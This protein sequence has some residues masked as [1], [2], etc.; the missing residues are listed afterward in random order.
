[1]EQK[2][3]KL[4]QILLILTLFVLAG[5]RGGREI[6]GL[7]AFHIL[8]LT[9]VFILLKSNLCLHKTSLDLSIAG[10]IIILTIATIVSLITRMRGGVFFLTILIYISL[11]YIIVRI[12]DPLFLKKFLYSIVFVCSILSII[13]C[14][15]NSCAN[16]PNE[17]L[18]A[19]FLAT[20]TIVSLCLIFSSQTGKNQKILLW[21]GLLI[22]LTAQILLFSRGAWV[23]LII[24]LAV[25]FAF[26]W[27]KLLMPVLILI[28]FCSTISLF[29]IKPHLLD[30]TGFKFFTPYGT[31][32]TLIWRVAL[33]GFLH[34]PLLGW[35]IKSFEN[36]YYKFALPFE[37][38]VGRY[39]RSTR[40]A[41][42][43]Y[44]HIAVETGIIG[45][46]IFLLLIFLV[47]K[48][49]IIWL[50]SD[51]GIDYWQKIAC[52]T[53][54]I[55]ILIHSLFDF[56]LH[57]PIITYSL[58]FFSANCVRKK[59]LFSIPPV[60]SIIA[61]FAVIILIIANI[62]TFSAFVFAK[63]FRYYRTANTINPLDSG[64]YER[65]ALLSTDDNIKEKFF[66]IAI[67]LDP[68]NSFLHQKLAQYYLSKSEFNQAVRHYTAAIELNP[69]NPFFYSELAEIYYK[70]NETDI[71]LKFYKKSVEL[72]PF[73][74]FAHYRMG[75]IF[76]KQNKK[77]LA[78]KAFQNIKKIKEMNLTPDSNYSKRLLSGT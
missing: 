22:I 30:K 21:I 34:K 60:V 41:H 32:R 37:E 2:S 66:N 73:Y 26:N 10:I 67:K 15:S 6:T 7:V 24:G 17:N 61:K 68:Q 25:L 64:Y 3:S 4:I 1:M 75:K 12:K 74:V 9:I 47:I 71:A 48:E 5:M 44:L 16:F 76:I 38:E 58:I 72:E 29:I 18:I 57:S 59:E 50:K 69:C 13:V 49:A 19:G 45:L 65:V 14:I 27:R 8:S 39:G 70:N 52:I 51:D 56:N 28:L 20:G 33:N 40:F 23:A 53:S 46:A 43:E 42:N 78:Q 55:A 63:Q 31:A 35:G 62:L 11:F 77:E 36:V 54:I